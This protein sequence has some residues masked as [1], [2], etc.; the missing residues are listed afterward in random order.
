MPKRVLSVHGRKV[1]IASLTLVPLLQERTQVV[2][3]GRVWRIDRSMFGA[4]SL[5]ED[6]LV[7]SGLFPGARSAAT[8][9]CILQVFIWP[10]HLCYEGEWICAR[11]Q[12]ARSPG[13]LA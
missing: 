11:L 4:V 8:R 1:V 12:P 6:A 5:L 2:G 13:Q 3:L 9:A 7:D 10:S